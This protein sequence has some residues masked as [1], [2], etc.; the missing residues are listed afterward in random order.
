MMFMKAIENAGSADRE[1]ITIALS[2]LKDFPTP[3]GDMSIDE[4][5]NPKIPI[6]IIKIQDGKRVYL[7]EVKPAF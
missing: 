5:H 3:F 2:K 1:K 4:N 6:G 7:E